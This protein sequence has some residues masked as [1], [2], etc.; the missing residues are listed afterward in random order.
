MKKF[1]RGLFPVPCAL[2]KAWKQVL[3]N[4]VM[5]SFAL[6]ENDNGPQAGFLFSF[7]W[8]QIGPVNLL[9]S[10]FRPLSQLLPRFRQEEKP[11]H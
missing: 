5:Q 7:Y 6:A 8:I 11:G 4:G 2:S 1:G 3:K 10:V 9:P